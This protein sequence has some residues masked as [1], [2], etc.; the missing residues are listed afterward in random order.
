MK[1][2]HSSTHIKIIKNFWARFLFLLKG[3]ES[4]NALHWCIVSSLGH[5]SLLDGE[6]SEKYFFIKKLLIFY[7][8]LEAT[9]LLKTL[10]NRNRIWLSKY[11]NRHKMWTSKM[12]TRTKLRLQILLPEHILKTKFCS[13]YLFLRGRLPKNI[14]KKSIIFDKKLLFRFFPI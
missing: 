8:Y 10:L 12:G 3:T 14:Y 1:D 11:G 13:G 9:S 7:K 4:L 2:S 6:Q 5:L